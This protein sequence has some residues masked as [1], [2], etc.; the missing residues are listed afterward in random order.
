[1]YPRFQNDV[2]LCQVDSNLMFLYIP[3]AYETTRLCLRIQ[4]ELLGHMQP[5]WSYMDV[6]V[7]LISLSKKLT[8]AQLP[9]SFESGV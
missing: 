7:S 6:H 3:C 2:Q 9:S 1:M 4:N 5:R 8:H